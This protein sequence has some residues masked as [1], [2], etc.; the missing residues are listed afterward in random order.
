MKQWDLL[1]EVE[2]DPTL[3]SREILDFFNEA[4]D[5]IKVDYPRYN[6]FNYLR[7]CVDKNATICLYGVGETQAD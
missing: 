3:S 6:E 4:N 7:I 5:S 2:I 1:N